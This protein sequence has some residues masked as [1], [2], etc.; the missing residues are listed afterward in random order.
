[1]AEPARPVAYIRSDAMILAAL[2]LG[3]GPERQP[4]TLADLLMEADPPKFDR[5]VQSR[6]SWQQ[7][8]APRGRALFESVFAEQIAAKGEPVSNWKPRKKRSRLTEDRGA[9]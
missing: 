6:R 5:E 9:E 8:L 2:V 4:V 7:T 3:G 1:M